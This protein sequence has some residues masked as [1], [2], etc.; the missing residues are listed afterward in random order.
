MA[1]RSLGNGKYEIQ[2]K[3]TG[4]KKVVSAEELPQYGLTA[5][6]EEKPKQEY[7]VKGLLDNIQVNGGEL[8][9]S[10]PKLLEQAMKVGNVMSPAGNK[11]NILNDARELGDT[12]M[13]GSAQTVS[14]VASFA[15]D[16]KK[17][18]YE[19]PVDTAMYA[20]GAAGLAPK[21]LKEGNYVRKLATKKGAAKLAEE[22]AAKADARGAGI[23]F[24]DLSKLIK[25]ETF[26][27]L[28]ETVEVKRSVEKLLSQLT[29]A[30]VDN[31]SP[32]MYNE[33]SK[34]SAT[35]LLEKR[36]QAAAR[37]GGNFLQKI[38]SKDNIDDKVD[39]IGR[40]KLSETLH[41]VAPETKTPDKAYSLYSKGGKLGGDIPTQLKRIALTAILTQTVGKAIAPSLLKYLIP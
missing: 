41:D 21:V 15:S 28:G 39:V 27:Q 6:Q 36:R 37:G 23:E 40:R 3:K 20:A 10:L 24:N 4:E 25:D 34:I 14:D 19:R 8:I 9:S 16:P 30:H 22:G 5:P 26:K 12:G 17:F 29:P 38:F 33:P 32:G 7:S 1:M 2:N 35:T 18:A 13:Q 11:S 31:P